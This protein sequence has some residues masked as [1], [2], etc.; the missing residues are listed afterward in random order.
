VTSVGQV[1]IDF[2]L[3]FD[4]VYI[5]ISGVGVC[6]QSAVFVGFLW[7]GDFVVHECSASHWVALG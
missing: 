2:A 3:G 1:C 4:H 6:F 7:N 5:E